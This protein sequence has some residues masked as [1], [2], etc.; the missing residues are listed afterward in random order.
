MDVIDDNGGVEGGKDGR[1][2][3][4]KELLVVFYPS[5]LIKVLR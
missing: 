3:E 1:T 4:W 2:G 5:R